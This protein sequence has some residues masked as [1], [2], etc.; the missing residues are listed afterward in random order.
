M[1]KSIAYV[2]SNNDQLEEI[3]E[4]QT[5]FKKVK[6]KKYRYRGRTGIFVYIYTKNILLSQKNQT[7]KQNKKA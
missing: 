1:Q 2:Y 5:P 3:V 4:K 6:V 7:P